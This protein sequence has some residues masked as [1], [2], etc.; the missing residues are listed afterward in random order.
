LVKHPEK[1][2]EFLK[3]VGI[4]YINSDYKLYEI[5]SV[6]LAELFNL[7]FEYNLG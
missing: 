6:S 7:Q 3:K 5:I 4:I 2:L 1:R